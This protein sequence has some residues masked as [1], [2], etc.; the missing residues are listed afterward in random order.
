[1]GYGVMVLE[2]KETLG[3]QVC[4]TGI[5]GQECVRSFAIGESVILRRANSAGLFAP[6]GSWLRLWRE[7]TQACIVD[8]GAF[9][10]DMANRAQD[11]GAQ[12]ILNSPVWNIEVGDKRVRVE[13]ACQEGSSSFEAR[14]AV[15]A[16]GFGSRLVERLG[17]GKVGDLVMGVQAEVPVADVDEIEV[18]FGQK[19][20]P[21]FFAWLVPISPDRALVGLLSRRSQGL[22][23][24]RLMSSL[25]AQ[26]K[27]VSDEAG[28]SYG[29]I[30]LKP[31]ART[32]GKRLVVVG[33]AA[34]QVKPTSGGGI[35]YGLLC[36]DIAADTLHQ[37]LK[38][39]VLSVRSL[40]DYER[41]WKRKL[42]RELRIGYWARKVYERLSDRQID[43]VFDIIRS[44]RIDEALL[45]EPELSFDWHGKLVLRLLQH[46]AVSTAMEVMKI[47][48]RLGGKSGGI[49]S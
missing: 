22:H 24:K 34:G 43:K 32:Y 8:R 37:A 26:G 18:Y 35:Y 11:K 48:F 46:R 42:G 31:L 28:L 14:V 13:V 17:L 2:Q 45:K 33:D 30:P 49:Q 40:A 27:I 41:G 38:S 44:Y 12:Y 29:G 47:P 7:E 19:I 6:S 15:I 5:I 39:D 36:A 23:L 1:M 10:L 20:A 9:D 4:C 3:G 21:G 16:N 25:V